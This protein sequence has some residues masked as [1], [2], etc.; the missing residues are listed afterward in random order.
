MFVL[1][2]ASSGVTRTSQFRSFSFS[3]RD[4][5]KR[6]FGVDELQTVFIVAEH[7]SLFSLPSEGLWV[8]ADV[9]EL[10]SEFCE[11]KNLVSS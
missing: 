8:S 4:K 11:N 2:G 5:S 10:L 9:L 1:N 6:F 3:E 7:S